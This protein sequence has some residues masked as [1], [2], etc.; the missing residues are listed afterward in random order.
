[1]ARRLVG[2]GV[3]PGDVVGVH[4]ERGPELVVSLLGVLKAGAAYTLLDPAFPA[5]RLATVVT[6]AEVRVLV[7]RDDLSRPLPPSGIRRVLL[8]RDAALIASLDDSDLGLVCGGS[9]AACVMFTSGS[10]GR[11]KGVV[12]PHRALVSTFVGPDYLGFCA[13][14]VY[15][16]SS[17]VS[18]DAFALEVFGALF[19]GGRTVLPVGSRTDLDEVAALVA[20]CGVTVLQLSASLFNVLVDD[21]PGLFAGLRAVMTAGEAA[22]VSHVARVCA[23][24]P[25]LRVLNGY[26]PVES[27]GFT[28]SHVVGGVVEGAG[29]VPI[30]VPLAGKRVFVLDGGLCAVPVGVPG[31]LYVA[32][33]GLAF[34]YVGRAGLTGERFVAC[35]FGGAGERMYRTG[36]VGRWRADGALEFLRRA[37]DQVKVRGFRIEPREVEAV[38][39]GHERVV[40][41]A[42]VV[43]ED[44]PGDR[45]LV[46]Y[47]VPGPD[48]KAVDPG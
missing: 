1:L 22:S 34:G 48:A 16:Q 44:R 8:D 10:T 45:R 13:D 23:R 38:L 41:C 25:G 29:S 46:A 9:G 26:G 11:P 5:E 3:V 24:H 37:D 30:G 32:G 4:L 28:T 17:P 35:P 33:S 6:D 14:D 31:E 47:A 7:T 36:D 2:V 19:H 18:W 39:S 21:F 43:R 20:G 40:Q 12:A 27:M 15:L 42:A